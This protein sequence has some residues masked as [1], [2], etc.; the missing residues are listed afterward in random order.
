[1]DFKIIVFILFGLVSS[2]FYLWCA[3]HWRIGVLYCW[4]ICPFIGLSLVAWWEAGHK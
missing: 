1:M 2:V 3:E 4:F